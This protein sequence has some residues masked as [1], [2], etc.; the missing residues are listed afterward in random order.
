MNDPTRANADHEDNDLEGRYEQEAEPA[1]APRSNW[2]RFAAVSL[3]VALVVGFL[4]ARFIT[5]SCEGEGCPNVEALKDYRPPEPPKIYDAGGNLAGQ[6]SGP[7]RVV[8]SYDDIP[9][10]VRDGYV[11]V[12][13]RRFYKHGGVDFTGGLRALTRN[14]SAGGIAEGGSTITMQ[15]ARNVFGPEVLRWNRFRRKFFEFRLARRI[16]A[17]LD[18]EEIL[19]LY[20]N[21]IYL[22][23]G[24]Y[25]VE[26]AAQHYFGKPVSEV[27]TREAALLIGLAK[28]PEGYNP[29]RNPVDAKDRIETVLDI[30]VREGV[31]TAGAAEEARAERVRVTDTSGTP[32][33]GKNAYYLSAV[34]R[35]LRQLYPNPVQRE[36]LR[37]HTGLDPLAQ[38]AAVDGLLS[39]IRSI[40]G[41]RWGRFRHETPGDSLPRMEYSPYLQG[42]VVAMDPSSGLVTTLVGGRDYDHSEFDRAFQALRQPGSAFKPIVYAAALAD[43]L[44]LSERISTEPVRLAQVGTPD[45]E[46]GDHVSG[47]DM[48]VRDA[49]VQSSNSATIRVG[50]RVGIGRVQQQAQRMGISTPIPSYPSVFLGAAD[51]IPA[52]LVASF[53]AF[54]NG[55]YTIQPHVITRIEDPDGNVVY[56]R[57]GSPGNRVLDPKVAFLMLDVMRDVVRRGTGY[58]VGSSGLSFPAAGKTGTTNDSKDVWFVG[59]TPS[60]VAGVWLGFDDPKT[61][62]SGGS[63]GDLAAPVWARFMQVANRG[64]KAVNSWNPPPGVVE[65]SVDARTGYAVNPECPPGE[66][67]TEYFLQGSQPMSGCPY[68][69]W[70]A[71]GDSLGGY[72][73]SDSLS[74]GRWRLDTLTSQLDSISERLRQ[75]RLRYLDS[76][77]AARRGGWRDSVVARPR[78]VD[79]VTVPARPTPRPRPGD[80]IRPTPRSGDTIA[81]PGG[82]G[83]PPPTPPPPPPPPDTTGG[84][85]G[86]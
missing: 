54:G 47:T 30:L 21:Q 10:I 5:P 79:T 82:S 26:T 57:H 27:S 20:L 4:G 83:A 76:L 39:Q 75:E 48:T 64:R 49:L 28:N 85:G 37:V 67:R 61:I 86:R 73:G 77:D 60:L 59:L 41:G 40:E 12:E 63:G 9:A 1:D 3:A 58:R 14:L 25:G 18:K 71:Y 46:P 11:A 43:G 22:G 72:P 78:P 52:E 50:Q 74:P 66:V 31:V 55:G 23:D 15:L 34:R 17:Q 2:G 45:W 53:A 80:T 69:D 38:A 42:M 44:R 81:G 19:A 36:G 7:K 13:D 16:E 51:V 29:R 24:V 56:Q 84:G 32:E 62:V 65:A 6:L 8:V 68:T 35:E 33:W 70:N